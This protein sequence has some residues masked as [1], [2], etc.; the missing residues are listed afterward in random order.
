MI[1]LNKTFSSQ[2]QGSAAV[3]YWP[4]IGTSMEFGSMIVSNNGYTVDSKNKNIH[5]RELELRMED[6]D[7]VRQVFLIYLQDFFFWLKNSHTH[8]EA[9]LSC[10]RSLISQFL[11]AKLVQKW[12]MYSL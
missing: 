8:S 4:E 1:K 2:K 11:L 7:Y 10:D 9:S 12:Q 5:I 6:S 3:V